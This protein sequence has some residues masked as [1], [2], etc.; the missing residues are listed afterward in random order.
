MPGTIKGRLAWTWIACNNFAVL[1]SVCITCCFWRQAIFPKPLFDH[2]VKQLES[3]LF[4]YIFTKTPTKDLERS[5]SVW[6]D[7]LREIG[8]LTNITE[9]KVGLNTFVSEKFKTSMASKE[10]ELVD[11]LRRYTFGSMQQYRTRYLLAKI[12]QYV[13]MAYKGIKIAGS[14]NEY[15]SLEIEHILPSKP[16]SELRESFNEENAGKEYDEYSA[17]LGNLTL[18]E[19]PINIVASN[20]FFAK[21]K[22]EYVKAGNYLTRSISGLNTVG[23]NTS[24][25]R[26]NEKL[27]AFETWSAAVIE[28]RQEMLIGLAMEVWRTTPMEV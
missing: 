24:I 4:Y 10:A 19:K 3:F 12:T 23:Y 8:Q 6:A 17:L 9:Q 27:R 16:E 2:L 22:L 18:L 5:F 21:K 25:M 1:H 15:S 28:D 14:L 7:D 13:D 11:S 20:D 26:I